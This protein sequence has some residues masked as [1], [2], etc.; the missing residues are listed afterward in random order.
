MKVWAAIAWSFSCIKGV[1][2][3]KTPA[4]CLLKIQVDKQIKDEE[5]QQV[6]EYGV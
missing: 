6:D 4:V 1:K 3:L 5:R 2:K